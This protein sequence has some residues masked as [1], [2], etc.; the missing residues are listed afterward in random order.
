[1]V[2]LPVYVDGGLLYYR[3]DRPGENMACGASPTW[4]NFSGIRNRPAGASAGPGPGSTAFAWQGAQYEGL[5]C[6]FLEFAGPT[7]GFRGGKPA[8]VTV[9]T[10]Q[11]GRPC[12]SCAT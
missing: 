7:G 1:V 2:A 10:P 6:D 8:E 5:V 12:G 3:K 9:D 4:T 11:N